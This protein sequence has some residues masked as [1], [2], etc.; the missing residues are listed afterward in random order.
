MV[1]GKRSLS[2]LDAPGIPRTVPRRALVRR[3]G[4][5][6]SSG[7]APTPSLGVERS[8][9]ASDARRVLARAAP[10]VLQWVPPDTSAA[11]PALPPRR[12]AFSGAISCVGVLWSSANGGR[13]RRR[14]MPEA[15]VSP[16]AA[17]RGTI[18]AFRAPRHPRVALPRSR[19][20][21]HPARRA[22]VDGVRH[23]GAGSRGTRR[24]P[25]RPCVAHVQ[26]AARA[27]RAIYRRRQRRTR[28]GSRQSGR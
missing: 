12:A 21:R 16:V 15:V 27:S 20:A 6:V 23:D 9:A 10:A 7:D 28:D 19:R 3:A 2:C 14:A 8:S 11:V 24:G 17:A 4:P 26:R 1:H 5:H 25:A 13:N 22:H 18:E